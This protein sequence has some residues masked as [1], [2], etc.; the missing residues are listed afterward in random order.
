MPRRTILA[1]AAGGAL[2]LLAAACLRGPADGTGTGSNA[3][4]G[5]KTGEP[6]GGDPVSGIETV[7]LRS[8]AFK[9]D[10]VTVKKGASIKFVN[11]DSP[12]HTVTPK[13]SGLP[14]IA[15][16]N[17]GE[18]GTLEFTDVGKHDY[19]CEYHPQMHL[20]IEVVEE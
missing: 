2:A 18:D 3:D 16:M 14:V 19:I 13:Q 12:P 5:A 6:A 11:D 15:N 4:P 9:P 10:T 7:Q 8:L 20:V 17:S 1:I